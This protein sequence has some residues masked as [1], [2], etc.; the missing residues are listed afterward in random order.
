MSLL[1]FWEATPL[2]RRHRALESTVRQTHTS[3]KAVVKRWALNV[4]ASIER[5][6]H[7][8]IGASRELRQI[9]TH[10][11][12]SLE[13][14][15]AARLETLLH[16]LQPFSAFTEEA[17]LFTGKLP[18]FEQLV[19]GCAIEPSLL[20]E[21]SWFERNVAEFMFRR[22]RERRD[23]T[24]PLLEDFVRLVR[25]IL[26]LSPPCT[27][28]LVEAVHCA[29]CHE[30]WAR[31]SDRCHDL[32]NTYNQGWRWIT[33]APKDMARLLR[34]VATILETLQAVPPTNVIVNEIDTPEKGL[35]WI[36]SVAF[37]VE[38]QTGKIE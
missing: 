29:L 24:E 34:I 38:F 7:L 8:L 3:N 12:A 16:S 21:S 18:P 17:Q 4:N 13:A 1:N 26:A 20:P 6:H 32:L 36:S 14:V 35:A 9:E 28:G 25:A 31:F 30:T 19:H 22:A 2:L 10:H 33:L 5:M 11:V 27:H 23:H 37:R 15:V